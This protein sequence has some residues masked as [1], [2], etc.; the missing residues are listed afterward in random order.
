MW[1]HLIFA[2]HQTRS[3]NVKQKWVGVQICPSESLG[4]GGFVFY[5]PTTRGSKSQQTARPP[6]GG[7]SQVGCFTF[8]FK[9]MI[10]SSL[11]PE[12]Y[13]HLVGCVYSEVTSSKNSFLKNYRPGLGSAQAAWWVGGSPASEG[14]WRL[15][16]GDKNA[17]KGHKTGWRV[18][19]PGAPEDWVRPDSPN[20]TEAAGWLRSDHPCGALEVRDSL[21][22]WRTPPHHSAP[23]WQG[24]GR[25]WRRDLL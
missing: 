9:Q 14:P 7:P 19:N 13:Q 6:S 23:R 11:A 21:S 10:L 20:P 3:L 5:K 2:F 8:L 22:L 1:M 24:V 18:R 17:L 25:L 4:E 12:K 15:A 16:V